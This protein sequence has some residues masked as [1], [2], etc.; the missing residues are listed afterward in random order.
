M[1]VTCEK[2]KTGI[3][4]TYGAGNPKE[5]FDVVIYYRANSDKDVAEVA[6][7]LEH[8]AKFIR[9]WKYSGKKV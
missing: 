4:Y 5:N 8:V 3:E 6:N 2:T 7:M 9:Q 1:K